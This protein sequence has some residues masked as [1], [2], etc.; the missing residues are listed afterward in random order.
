MQSLKKNKA[1]D[2]LLNQVHGKNAEEVQQIIKRMSQA[3]GISN[4]RIL[5]TEKELKKVAPTYILARPLAA[6]KLKNKNAKC[7]ISESR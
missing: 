2:C 4:Y 7:K 1:I 3:G 5:V 6:V